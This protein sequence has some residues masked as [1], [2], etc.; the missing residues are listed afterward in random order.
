[1]GQ[2]HSPENWCS[3][4]L[5]ET[6]GSSKHACN[7]TFSAKLNESCFPPCIVTH[8]EMRTN[9]GDHSSGVPRKQ[10]KPE[11]FIMW[12]L[13]FTEIADRLLRR[14]VQRNWPCRPANQHRRRLASKLPSS[15][16]SRFFNNLGVFTWGSI[17][18]TME[19]QIERTSNMTWKLA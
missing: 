17:P 9:Y 16:K 4:Q 19:I 7:A 12:G 18:P 2:R 14:P 6:C 3:A 15:L 11:Q 5:S 8:S 13:G 1:M 10:V